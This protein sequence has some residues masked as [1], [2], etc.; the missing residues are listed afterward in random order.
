[1]QLYRAEASIDPADVNDTSTR[2]L[3]GL[4]KLGSAWTDSYNM[5]GRLRD[6]SQRIR[7]W[8]DIE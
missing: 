2:H 5:R 3:H 8:D 6:L 7:T 1:M 4:L